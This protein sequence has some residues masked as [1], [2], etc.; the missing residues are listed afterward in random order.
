MYTPKQIKENYVDKIQTEYADVIKIIDNEMLTVAT[1]ENEFRIILPCAI[2]EKALEKILYV[3]KK[4]YGWAD[5]TFENKLD[6]HKALRT[7]ITFK[8][9]G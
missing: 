6:R 3:Y 5:I 9:N 2:E 8:S 7:V 1:L 4:Y